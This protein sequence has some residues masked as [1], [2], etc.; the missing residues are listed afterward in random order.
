M[1]FTACFIKETTCTTVLHKIQKKKKELIQ[2]FKRSVYSQAERRVGVFGSCFI[3]K[4]GSLKWAD[5]TTAPSVLSC[6]KVTPVM[7]PAPSELH[8]MKHHGRTSAIFLSVLSMHDETGFFFSLRE[9]KGMERRLGSS[10]FLECLFCL[11]LNLSCIVFCGLS[12]T[13]VSCL[14]LPRTLG[15]LP[16]RL[17]GGDK[18]AQHSSAPLS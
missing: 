12:E 16:C 15:P 10:K 13:P 11:L 4:V 8:E 7:S 5:C 14:L 18:G 6:V 9:V 2:G 17:W 3:S 1:R